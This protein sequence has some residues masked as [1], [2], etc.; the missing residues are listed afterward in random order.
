MPSF[1]HTRADGFYDPCPQCAAEMSKED[2]LKV[3]A[4]MQA[5][6]D[7]A[8]SSMSDGDLADVV[9]TRLNAILSSSEEVRS[10]IERLVE[11]R[12]PCSP[13]TLAHPTIQ[14][15]GN[16]SGGFTIG[17]LG[18][19]NGLVGVRPDSTGH[20]AAEFGDSPDGRLERFVRTR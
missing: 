15:V 10:D 12:I 17:F 11:T 18:L 5:C 8:T 7:D 4:D 3:I 16:P 14:A 9:I 6:R 13:G 2:L 19:L 1:N 20:I